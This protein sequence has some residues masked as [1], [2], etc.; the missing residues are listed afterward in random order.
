MLLPF[1]MRPSTCVFCTRSIKERMAPLAPAQPYTQFEWKRE[2]QGQ[3]VPPAGSSVLS[4]SIEQR[5]L[6]KV[7]TTMGPQ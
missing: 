3:G 5:Y 6:A 4:G 7:E 1:A 2:I